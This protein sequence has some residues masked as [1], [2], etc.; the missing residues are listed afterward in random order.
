MM[1]PAKVWNGF[2]ATYGLNNSAHWRVFAQREMCSGAVV[3]VGIVL[4]HL[5]EMAFAQDHDMIEA[6]PP[7]RADETLA[8]TV[9]PW[10]SR[11]CWPVPNAYCPQPAFRA[12]P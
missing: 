1:E 8:G 9:L 5:P 3:I 2:D 10:G 4:Q 7:D 12:S 11:S 6:V